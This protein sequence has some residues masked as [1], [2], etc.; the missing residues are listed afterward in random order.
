MMV[1][2]QNVKQLQEGLQLNPFAAAAGGD[3]SSMMNPMLAAAAAAAMGAGG[4]VPM[5]PSNPAFAEFAA[6]N[7]AIFMQ[8]LQQQQIQALQQHHMQQQLQQ[9]REQHQQQ[10]PSHGSPGN[11]SS[12]GATPQRSSPGSPGASGCGVSGDGPM[13][14]SAEFPTSEMASAASGASLLTQ[15]GCLVASEAACSS[16]PAST[17]NGGNEPAKLFHCCICNLFSND[18]VDILHQ[19]MALDRTG[20]NEHDNL[21]V[22]GGNYVCNLCKYKTNLRANFQVRKRQPNVPV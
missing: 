10:Q 5:D 16:G 21:T 14:L 7:Q 9:Q 18:N 11:S 8:Q 4:G 1:L 6:Y 20:H 2:Q 15:A 19:H 17:S 12:P 22:N 13:D 3:P